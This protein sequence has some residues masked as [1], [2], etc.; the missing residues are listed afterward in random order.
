MRVL[1]QN[2]YDPGEDQVASSCENGKEPSGSTKC[3]EFLSW[4]RNFKHNMV[5]RISLVGN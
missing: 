1:G 3:E 2:S 5:P 4:P